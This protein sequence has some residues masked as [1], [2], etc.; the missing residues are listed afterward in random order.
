MAIGLWTNAGWVTSLV[1]AI[2]NHRV[3]A[4]VGAVQDSMLDSVPATRPPAP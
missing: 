4:V 1:A 3:A 2:V